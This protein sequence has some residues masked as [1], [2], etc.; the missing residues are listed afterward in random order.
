MITVPPTNRGYAYRR[1]RLPLA[2]PPL[3]SM[4]AETALIRNASLAILLKRSN[5][6]RVREYSATCILH[7]VAVELDFVNPSIAARDFADRSR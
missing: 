2:P 5:I 3:P 6:C 7:A 4:M 1:C